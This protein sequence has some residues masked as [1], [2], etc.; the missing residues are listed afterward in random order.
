MPPAEA[1]LDAG[2]AGAADPVLLTALHST[3][4]NPPTQ[5]YSDDLSLAIMN[6]RLAELCTAGHWSEVNALLKNKD[7]KITGKQLN[8]ASRCSPLPQVSR[9]T[10][11]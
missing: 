3:T 4:K 5:N 11:S 8:R 2:P 9:L 1:D 6:G 7:S 10:I